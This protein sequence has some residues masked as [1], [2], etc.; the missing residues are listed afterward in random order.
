MLTTHLRT[1]HLPLAVAITAALL[2]GCGRSPQPVAAD[3]PAASSTPAPASAAPP[4]ESD[5]AAELAAKEKELADREALL[6]QREIEQELA[7]RDAENSAAAAAAAAKTASNRAPA[8]KSTST[9][10]PPVATAPA[11]PAA[12]ASAPPPPPPILVPAGTSLGIQLA[13]DVSSKTANP[14]DAVQGRL[15]SDLVV[16]GRRVAAAGSPVRGSVTQVVSGSRTVGGTP[17]LAITF[18]SLSVTG[19]TSAAID[20]KFQQQAASD[21]GKDAA[22]I[23]GGAAAGAVIG[24]QVNH[25]NGAIFGGLIGGAAGTAVAK[26]TGGEVSLPAGTVVNVTTGAAFEIAGGG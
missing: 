2:A 16:G 14:G 6:K 12:T 1:I 13:A 24:H 20:A 25:K 7:R 18:D 9:S 10:R 21:T 26:G 4:P 5:R 22:K 19:G 23:V 15:A 11:A 17:T 8:K 3:A